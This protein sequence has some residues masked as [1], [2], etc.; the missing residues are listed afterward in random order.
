VNDD[1]SSSSD[2]ADIELD[3]N[4]EDIPVYEDG[5]VDGEK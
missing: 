3:T 1:D 2:G 5:P 4:D